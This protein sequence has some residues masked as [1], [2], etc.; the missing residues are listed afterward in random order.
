MKR[1][2]EFSPPAAKNT[3]EIGAASP[4]DRGLQASLSKR[5]RRP[6]IYLLVAPSWPALVQLRPWFLNGAS[7]ESPRKLSRWQAKQLLR[8]LDVLG[9]FDCMLASGISAVVAAKCLNVSRQTLWRWDNARD[10]VPSTD[11]C[12]RKPMR[13]PNAGVSPVRQDSAE[14]QRASRGDSRKGGNTFNRRATFLARR[15]S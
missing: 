9:Q 15:L 4:A 12:G 13:A 5:Q 14:R 10:L 11:R 7:E 2:Y 3:E 1:R 6:L 8:R